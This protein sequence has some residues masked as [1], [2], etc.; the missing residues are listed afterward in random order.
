VNAVERPV[1]FECEGEELIAILSVPEHPVELGVVVVV[2]GPQYRAGSHRQFVYLARAL[3]KVRIP[4]LRFDYRG[5]GDSDGSRRSFDS[6]GEDI[7]CAVRALTE[8]VPAVRRVVLWGLCDG[9]SAALMAIG[10]L[11]NVGGLIALN[12]W[13]RSETSL[14]RALVT[15]YYAQRFRSRD[16]WR[17]LLTGRLSIVRAVSEF[18]RRASSAVAGRFCSGSSNT[19]T[20]FQDRMCDGLTRSSKPAMIVL[21]GND[22]TAQ[23]YIAFVASDPRWTKA[24]ASPAVVT[25]HVSQADH[26]FS[27]ETSR[28]ELE[29]L[30]CDFVLSLRNADQSQGTTDLTQR[31]DRADQ[32]T[33]ARVTRGKS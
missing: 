1:Q 20:R 12:P 23:E 32:R 22:L 7:A 11:P 4:C 13:T 15:H 28:S 33:D 19:A 29:R 16:F 25:K 8:H 2:G 30:C 6:V 21:S 9:A 10:S 24:L 5:M 14:D 3:A 27:N 17:K 31:P 26:T 18:A